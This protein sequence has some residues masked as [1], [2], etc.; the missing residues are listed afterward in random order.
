M[1]KINTRKLADY[2]RDQARWREQKAQEWEDERNER[3]ARALLEAAEY[4][5]SLDD[6]DKR[7]RM[8]E[9]AKYFVADVCTLGDEGLNLVR[10]WNFHAYTGDPVELIDDLAKAAAGRDYW[11]ALSAEELKVAENRLRRMAR[12]QG[13][14]LQK[15]RR[16]DIRAYDYGGWMIIDAETN[17]VV[18]GGSPIAYS[19]SLSD[20]ESR[21]NTR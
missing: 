10:T 9:R 11:E 4:V 15:S 21:L 5:E 17:A 12:R 16:R 13:L 6:S 14:L 19:L 7:I 2:L 18:D 3:S 8:M 20:V 1:D